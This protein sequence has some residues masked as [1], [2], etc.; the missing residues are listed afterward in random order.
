VLHVRRRVRVFDRRV[1]VLAAVVL[2]V[3]TDDRVR[4]VILRLG[5]R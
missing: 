3:V 4:D 5:H 1:A 2:V